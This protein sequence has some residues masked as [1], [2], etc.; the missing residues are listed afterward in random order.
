[1]TQSKCKIKKVGKYF[2]SVLRCLFIIK[3]T[4]ATYTK[5]FSMANWSYSSSLQRYYY[6]YSALIVLCAC[7]TIT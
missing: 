1:M 2:E 6:Y 5:C 7:T 4:T 3:E